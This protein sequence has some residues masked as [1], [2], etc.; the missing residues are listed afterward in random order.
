MNIVLCTE[1]GCELNMPKNFEKN[2]VI[3]CPECG[4]TLEITS[5]DPVEV[6]LAEE[7]DED[8]GE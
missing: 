7:A 4:V 2:E 6:A 8:W 5:V 1:C 3:V